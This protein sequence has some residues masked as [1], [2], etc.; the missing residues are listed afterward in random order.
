MNRP[1]IKEVQMYKLTILNKGVLERHS[2]TNYK[3]AHRAA[4][5]AAKGSNVVT[6]R[7]LNATIHY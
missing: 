5:A 7:F 6:L 4:R 1:G 3:A 2:F